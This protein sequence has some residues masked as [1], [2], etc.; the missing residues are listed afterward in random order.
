MNQ[1]KT[2]RNK[3][4]ESAGTLKRET[5]FALEEPRRAGRVARTAGIALLALIVANALPIGYDNAEYGLLFT[6]ALFMLNVVSTFVFAI[7]YI[8]R[9]WV[10]D[11]KYPQLG[12]ARSRIRYARS[13]MGIVDL[14]SCV[15][16]MFLWLWPLSTTLSD[17]IRIVRLVRLVKISRYMRGLRT[18]IIVF[19]KRKQE[20]IAAFMVLALVCIASSVLVFEAEHRVQPDKFDSIFSGL[21]WALTTMTSTGYGDL[22]PITPFGRLVGGITMFLSIGVVAI[23]AGIFSAGFVAEF[24]NSDNRSLDELDED[25]GS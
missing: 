7:E 14:L 4:L 13:A 2:L 5:Y 6:Q 18:I 11:I 12:P 15:P 24:R 8:L 17:A 1:T 23:P 19:E 22:A 9:L 16:M 3:A 25:D 20:I 10:A 21:Y